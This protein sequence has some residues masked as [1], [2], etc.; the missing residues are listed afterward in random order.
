MRQLMCHHARNF[1]RCQSIE[2]AGR[3]CNGS[4][5][6]VAARCKGIGLVFVDDINLRH[7]QACIGSKTSDHAIIIGAGTLIDF[8]RIV[9][10][11]NHLVG[12]PV[13]KQVHRNSDH[14]RD[15]HAAAAAQQI[16]DAHEHD[17]H[18]SNQHGSFR[19]IHAYRSPVQQQ[20]T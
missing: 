16:A 14:Q 9:H 3:G 15:H 12:I 18:E 19:H 5:F 8:L 10:A 13:A 7:R 6:R 2:K 20:F 11:Q 1:F 4:I 17:C